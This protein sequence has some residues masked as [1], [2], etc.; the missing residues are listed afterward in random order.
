MRMLTP[1]ELATAQGFPLDY[2]I[3][4]GADGKPLTKTAQVRMIGNSV[5]PPV[6]AALV[7]ANFSHEQQR[8]KARAA[9]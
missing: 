9:A 4:R 5:C 8:T 7:R 1:R 3:D 6:A 2:V